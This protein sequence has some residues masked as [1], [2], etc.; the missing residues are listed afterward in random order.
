VDVDENSRHLNTTYLFIR[1]KY[2]CLFNDILITYQRRNQMLEK[3]NVENM[4][5]QQ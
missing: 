3:V 4:I 1:G 2:P 5:A